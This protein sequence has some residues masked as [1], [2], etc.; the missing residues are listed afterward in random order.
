[1]FCD[2]IFAVVCKY[3]QL[4]NYSDQNGTI[5]THSS[6]NIYVKS[7]ESSDRDTNFS[8]IQNTAKQHILK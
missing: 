6:I 4:L 7:G 2:N 3:K 1:M 5:Y 8:C